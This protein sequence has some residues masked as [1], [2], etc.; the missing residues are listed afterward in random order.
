MLIK[1]NN[2]EIELTDEQVKEI[3][4]KYGKKD[5][6]KDETRYWLITHDGGKA[7]TRWF[8]E[9]NDNF[10]RDT[11]NFYLKES[12]CD[13]AVEKAHALAR[14]KRFIRENELE[15]GKWVIC[16]EEHRNDF[17]THLQTLTL[18]L[19]PRLSLDSANLLIK[20]MKDDLLVLFNKQ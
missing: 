3:V 15:S 8:N 12:D 4:D 9:E 16:Y 17:T 18:E 20:K 1:L 14:V 6:I 10:R 5:E 13:K 7:S 19:L 2:N 11:G